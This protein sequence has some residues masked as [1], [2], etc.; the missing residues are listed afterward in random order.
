MV[1]KKPKTKQIKDKIDLK[2]LN[3]NIKRSLSPEQSV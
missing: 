3:L 1:K 2:Q